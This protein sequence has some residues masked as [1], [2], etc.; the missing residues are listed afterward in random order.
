MNLFP[1]LFLTIAG[2]AAFVYD[3]R[4]LRCGICRELVKDVKETIRKVGLRRTV[5]VGSHRVDHEGN[6]RGKKIPLV[7][8]ESFLADSM[9]RF[10][11]SMDDYARGIDKMTGRIRLVRIFGPDGGANPEM[12]EIEPISD[13]NMNRSLFVHCEDIIDQYDQE[14]LTAFQSPEGDLERVCTRLELCVSETREE[15]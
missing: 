10:C 12:D 2:A 14:L 5:R 8:S 13:S 4:D 1:V 7:R 9:D 6:V 11:R 3:V 15:L